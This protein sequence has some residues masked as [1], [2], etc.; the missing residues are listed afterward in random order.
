VFRWFPGIV[1][2]VES[3]PSHAVERFAGFGVSMPSTAIDFMI[4][5]FIDHEL[6]RW[7][8]VFFFGNISV[9]RNNFF[10]FFLRLR[11]TGPPQSCRGNVAPLRPSV[12]PS[13]ALAVKMQAVP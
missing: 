12:N 3:V 8:F 5:Y 1:F 2:F 13:L 7:M 6:L 11:A 4:D 9:V 10:S